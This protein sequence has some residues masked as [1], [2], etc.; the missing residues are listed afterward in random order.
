VFGFTYAS[1]LADPT[2][3][4]PSWNFNLLSTIA[5][6][7]LHSY[8]NG[9]LVADADWT[10]FNSPAFASMVSTAHA[11]GVKVVVTISPLFGY[12]D[13]VD[14][15]DTLFNAQGTVNQL[16][17]QVVK[18]GIDGVNIDYEGQ[19]AT[20]YSTDPTFPPSETDQALVTGLAADMRA[21]LD[22]AKPGYYLS[23]DT[24]SGSASGNDGF[25]NI[26]NLNQYVDSF[27]VMAYD[28]DYSNSTLPPLNCSRFCLGPV[29]PLT[30][31]YWNDT[32]SASQYSSVVG[33]GKVILGQ[34]YY[35]RVACVSSPS[36]HAYP[37]S[38]VTAATYLGAASVASSPDV[39][40]GTYSTGRDATDA[41]GL[42][43]WDTWYDN[44]LNCWREMYWDDT[45]TLGTKYNLVNRDNLR[46]VGIWTL[47]Y[48]GSAPELWDLLS[49]Y[50]QT[51]S[52]GYDMSQAPTSWVAGQTQTFPVTVTNSGTFTWPSNGANPVKLDLHFASQPGTSP[53]SWLTSQVYSLPSDVAPG[54]SVTLTVT[55]TAPSATGSLY[56]EAEMF[57]N[58]QFWFG[59]RQ[60][61]LVTV[62]PQAWT[63]H[64]DMSQAPVS[65]QS[66]Q[67][68]SFPVTI[69]NTGNVTWPAVGANPVELDLHF[70]PT[71][72][73]SDNIYSWLTSQVFALS[74]DVPPNGSTTVTVSVTAPAATG[75]LSLEA[76]MFK[77]QQFWF[78]QWQPV[79]VTVYGAWG[80]SDDLSQAPTSWG[81][82]QSKTFQV[83]VT[84]QGTQPWPA[85]GVNPVELDM[86]F[87]TAPGGSDTQGNWLTSETYR[88]A[89]DVAPGASATLSVTVTAPN[90]A[91]A[92]YLE[93]EM[94]KNQQFWFQQ[95]TS[96]PITLVPAWV[97]SYDTCQLPTVW[98]PGK[99]QTVSITLT[100]TG[101]ATWPSSGPNPVELDLHFT[102]AAGGSNNIYS[103][104]T[105]QVYALPNDVAPGG[106]VTLSVNA[107]AP[108]SGGSVYMEAE[109]F[110]NQQFWFQQWQ[111]APAVVG[112]PAWGVNYNTCAAPRTWTKGQSQT[113]QVT[114]TNAG[115]QTWPAGG[116]N[117]VDLDLHFTTV[118][119]GNAQMSN[120]L[121]GY[122]FALPSDVAPG[123][124]VTV[125]VTIA[126]PSTS[127]TMYIEAQAFKNQQFWIQEWQSVAVTVS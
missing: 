4:Y 86:H 125:S 104:L 95:W 10:A 37:T 115:T 56:L 2:V 114:L 97:A 14:F 1:S 127:G 106:S 103:W 12:G 18:M 101:A 110:K 3:G 112:T 118:P 48:G 82:G 50:F 9:N 39:R 123:Q 28:M 77:N 21:G 15:C 79:S 91:G 46:G 121:N 58:Q 92:L 75:Y 81:A 45:T 107:T 38:N 83:T 36:A 32:N 105:S 24:Y 30:N 41:A 109:L 31:Y 62:V 20:C 84:N 44:S 122:V 68:K 88:L 26:P 8:Y 124:S 13:F 25:F 17:P 5:F 22:K 27:F 71:P 90:R 7:S 111:A 116:A 66:G 99:S 94:F 98:T 67:T 117:P 74:A 96:V 51:W 100:N 120:W 85:G 59:Q 6:F 60:P 35:G 43:R 57:K 73:G 126:A 93:A 55:A 76:E 40:S 108:S 61:S 33:A 16:V 42:D 72:G 52:A 53:Y 23:I 29:S 89:S 69:T 49:A 19:L 87:T 78:H 11:H 64:Y 113:F 63:A 119:G 102:P 34:P 47:N 80:A 54:A 65:W 70:T